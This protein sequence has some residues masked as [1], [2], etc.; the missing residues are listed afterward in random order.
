MTTTGE[1]ENSV[2]TISDCTAIL[3]DLKQPW[4]RSRRFL[5]LL[6]TLARG[7]PARKRR[8]LSRGGHPR[9]A[10]VELLGAHQ[11]RLPPLPIG[12]MTAESCCLPALP[13][14]TGRHPP[15]CQDHD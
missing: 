6:V 13:N 3:V 9:P 8:Y 11:P 7:S 12:G 1:V 14:A 4:E 2:S 15:R 10:R 5:E